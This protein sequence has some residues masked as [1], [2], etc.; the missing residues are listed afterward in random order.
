MRVRVNEEREKERATHFIASF[1]PRG[2]ISLNEIG[3]AAPSSSTATSLV[4]SV[5]ATTLP[6]RG[7]HDC[8]DGGAWRWASSLENIYSLGAGKRLRC[9]AGCRGI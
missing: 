4:P 2:F 7:Q 8:S 1:N 9:N 3:V 5:G 6:G